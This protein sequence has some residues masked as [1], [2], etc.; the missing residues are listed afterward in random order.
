MK[1][2]DYL[3]KGTVGSTTDSYPECQRGDAWEGGPP[4]AAPAPGKP[5][6][7]N[8]A[9]P[10]GTDDDNRPEIL[11]TT[12]EHLVNQDA[13]SALTRDSSVFQRGGLLV[14]IVR[15][16]RPAGKGIR[17]PFSPRIEPLPQA[18][19][20]ERLAANAQWIRTKG[21]PEEELRVPARPPTWC[22]AAVH[23]RA[24]WQGMAALEAVI[25]YP[26]LRPDGSILAQPGYD[27][28]TE[29]LLEFKDGPLPCP[30]AP[31]RDDAI[32]ARDKLLDVVADFPFQSRLHRACWLA[33][34]L[35]PLAR[36]AFFGPAPLFLVDAN[37][38]GAG[39]GLL[40]DCISRTISGER[41][42]IATYTNDED[43]LRKRITSMALSGERLVLFDNLSGPFGDPV[44]DAALTATAWK[45]RILGGNR[46]VEAPLHM[47]WFATG[48]NVVIG[49][50]TARRTC[51]IR[52]ESPEEH[53]ENRQ[54]FRH[55]NLLA[56]VSENRRQF[57]G[58]AL[59]ILRGYCAAG[60][61]SL[62]LP[63]W[64]SF[65]AWSSLVRSAVV[66]VDLPDPGE[67]RLH[68]QQQGD[69]VAEN[70]PILLRL[71]EGMDPDRKGLTTAAVIHRLYDSKAD[72]TDLPDWHADL[73]A[74]LETLLTRRDAR[75]LGNKLR[76]HRRRIFGGRFIDHAGT[77]QGAVRWAA[78]K[79]SEFGH[80][81]EETHESHQTPRLDARSESRES[82]ESFPMDGAFDAP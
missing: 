60:R 55:P 4:S 64:G 38:P 39:K 74:T 46:I 14:R 65:E 61:P 68:L 12:D 78:F 44:L 43:E 22:V 17:R 81:A 34:L 10:A 62:N 72:S 41:F 32:A 2:L 13:V 69:V 8:E 58:A 30:D 75:G 54:E 53:P 77:Q 7:R 42:T 40:L 73:K 15:D 28:K 16:A 79:A 82:E 31:S 23:A 35:T 50:D 49:A 56:W 11:I 59:T 18:I 19:L 25:D 24:E 48:N 20:R 26:V 80:R 9:L 63:A 52:L 5:N 51:H 36:F 29:L 1:L 37:V 67:S 3:P 45:D 71:W 33:A 66:W 21:D 6:A 70:M 57:L 47:T 76:K 27:P